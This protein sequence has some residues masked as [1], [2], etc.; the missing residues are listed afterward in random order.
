MRLVFPPTF[1]N[2]ASSSSSDELGQHPSPH[3]AD[4]ALPKIS[5]F[6]AFIFHVAYLE[7]KLERGAKS[8][9][10]GKA[11]E[12]QVAFRTHIG[13]G[14]SFSVERAEPIHE[15]R[16]RSI[17]SG[18]SS[19]PKERSIIY[20]DPRALHSPFESSRNYATTLGGACPYCTRAVSYM[21]T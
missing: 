11:R 14:V 15:G 3:D 10:F 6:A 9:F 1:E 13:S 4:N 20:S 2:E 18:A 17:G 8:R 5:G 19:G 7:D 21:G 12:L 16:D